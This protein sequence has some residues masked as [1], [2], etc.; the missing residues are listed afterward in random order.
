MVGGS[1]SIEELRR[2]IQEQVPI[3][4]VVGRYVSL[5]RVG[6]S[7][8]ALCPFHTEK[9]PSFYVAPHLQIFKC[10]GCNAGGDVITFL[11]K[12]EGWSFWEA[13]QWLAREYQINVDS[14]L[15]R[16]SDEKREGDTH[17][18]LRYALMCALEFFEWHFWSGGSRGRRY[19][20]EDRGFSGEVLRVFRIGYAPEDGHALVE[21]LQ[22]KHVPLEVA[23]EAGV[24][25]RQGGEWR[26]FFR[27]Q[28]IFPIL[29]AR[30]QPI[31]FA[32]RTIDSSDTRPKYINTA[33][34]PLFVKSSA[35]FGLAQ[36]FLSVRRERRVYLVEGY[37]DVLAMW[38]AGV[39]NVVATCGTALTGDHA[40]YLSRY[41]REVVL[42]FD[43]DAAGVEARRRAALWLYPLNV[44]VKTCGLPSE[45]KDP[46]EF[47][48]ARGEEALKEWLNKHERDFFEWYGALLLGRAGDSLGVRAEVVRQLLTL[49]AYVSDELQREEYLH[50]LKSVHPSVSLGVL[51]RQLRQIRRRVVR[52]GGSSGGQWGESLV[53][54]GVSRGV[55]KG[56]KSD[57]GFALISAIGVLSLLRALVHLLMVCE[58]VAGCCRRAVRILELL[59]DVARA[60]GE[61]LEEVKLLEGLAGVCRR[62]LEEASS[63]GGG[64]VDEG[65]G[66]VSDDVVRRFR[67]RLMDWLALLPAHYRALF[68]TVE[69][70]GSQCQRVLSRQPMRTA[71]Q[72]E[73]RWR[74]L[75]A[76]VM[77]LYY[78]VVGR[79]P[80]GMTPEKLWSSLRWSGEETRR[81]IGV[82]FF[83]K[84]REKGGGREGGGGGWGCTNRGHSHPRACVV[85]AIVCCCVCVWASFFS[86]T[87]EIRF[88]F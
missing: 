26:S 32:G 85:I 12:I 71:D 43:S 11:Q 47:R 78:R 21:Y 9:T 8:R 33:N 25:V 38:M 82:F 69:G 73:H 31:G 5:K 24:V 56:G 19:V 29:D 74:S 17:Q 42:V 67:G 79:L 75:E 44:R 61:N 55:G 68:Y 66:L 48:R 37:F 60:K 62:V 16:A 46:D 84:G 18:L 70:E 35:F 22:K 1:S 50:W 76:E 41:V 54:G 14:F 28:L 65:E 57:E 23:Q 63:M 53:G 36:S 39:R 88:T 4:E 10:F 34:T 81:T 58:D 64:V 77:L 49:L 2:L 80:E 13:V 83:S 7:F 86:T 59:I 40:R 52:G 72:V 6:N 3:E 51:R 45:Y 27:D 20:E 15:Q 87:C 30:G